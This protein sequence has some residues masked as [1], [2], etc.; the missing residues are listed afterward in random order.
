MNSW[1]LIEQGWGL[2]YTILKAFAF[3]WYLFLYFLALTE[4]WLIEINFK[5]RAFKEDINFVVFFLF[6]TIDY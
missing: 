6:V 5:K 3:L 4:E 2:P 1:L